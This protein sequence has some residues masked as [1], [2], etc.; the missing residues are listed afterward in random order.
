MRKLVLKLI[1]DNFFDFLVLMQLYLILLSDFYPSMDGPAHLYNSNVLSQIITGNQFL[2]DY[3]SINSFYIPNWMANLV[4]ALLM[5]IFNAEIAEKILMIAY[6]VGMA[7]SFRYLIRQINPQNEIFSI[8][9]FPFIFSFLFRLGFYNF[10]IAFIFYFLVTGFWL[11]NHDKFSTKDLLIL[12]L[13]ITALYYSNVLIF[14]FAGLSI[15]FH[16]VINTLGNFKTKHSFKE[17]INSMLKKT[18]F[19]LTASICSLISMYLFYSRVNFFPSDEKYPVNELLRW[20]NDV[21]PLITYSYENEAPITGHFLNIFIF[22]FSIALYKKIIITEKGKFRISE[23]MLT[24]LFPVILSFV[25]LFVITDGSGAAMM[26]NRFVLMFYIFLTVFIA[27]TSVRGLLSNI[28]LIAFII[29]NFILLSR[30]HILSI[31]PLSKDAVAVY[32]AGKKIKPN[33][34]VLPVNLSDNWLQG[35]FSNYLGAEKPIV[36]LENYEA[37]VGWFPLK[38]NNE[39]I[40]NLTLSGKKSINSVDWVKGNDKNKEKQIDYICI[41]GNIKKIDEPKYSELKTVINEYFKIKHISKNSF[42]HIY[43]RN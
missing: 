26:S 2:T 15:G 34:L 30:H 10:S 14:G 3:Y 23:T 13:L 31:N 21:R 41:T 8:L 18:L 36:I 37:S 1:K 20:I 38:W 39:K 25:A 33:T 17:V 24:I 43:E 29:L 7:Y 22:L 9:I 27:A 35:H 5:M 12:F 40:P 42:V 6:V 19:I 32:E 16:I 28:A 4:L 11:K